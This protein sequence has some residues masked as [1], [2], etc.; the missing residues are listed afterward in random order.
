MWEAFQLQTP[1]RVVFANV[2][3]PGISLGLVGNAP[4]HSGKLAEIL[5]TCGLPRCHTGPRTCPCRASTAAPVLW[6][7]NSGNGLAFE[8]GFQHHGSVPGLDVFLD[9]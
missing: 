4:F 9:E 1:T 5:D 8:D 7:R 3:C 6:A 2:R